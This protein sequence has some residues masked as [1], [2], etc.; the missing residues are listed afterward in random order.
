VDLPGSSAG[1]KSTYRKVRDRASYAF[2]L[3]SVAA[4]LTVEGGK[5]REVRLA[6]G[7]VAHKPWRATIAEQA[8]SGAEANEQQF[9]RAAEAELAPAAPR[10]H[11]GFK[12]ELARRTIVSVLS[13][14][15]GSQESVQ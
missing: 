14:L 5:V 3:V 10:Q 12:I 13:E 15:A 11:N 7:G 8:L 1:L 2:A 4:S 6:L 9:S